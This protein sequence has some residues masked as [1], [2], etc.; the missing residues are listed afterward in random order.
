MD[1]N[2][3]QL[4]GEPSE[5]VPKQGPTDDACMGKRVEKQED[6]DTI[7]VGYCRAW[8]GKGTGHVGE[9]RCSRHGGGAGAP[10]GNDNATGN[11]G[12]GA[13]EENDNAVTHAAFRENFTDTLTE[14]GE[15]LVEQA[16]ELLNDPLDAQQVGRTAAG[17]ALEKFRRTGSERFLRRFESICDTFGLAPEDIQ[18]HEHEHKGEVDH[19]HTAELTDQQQQLLESIEGDL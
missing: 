12:G 9:G 4:I 1:V 8:P 5:A 14:S 11:G 2:E 19:R 13:P 18:K 6:G 15:Q 3:D 10:E 17:L 16:E 7:F